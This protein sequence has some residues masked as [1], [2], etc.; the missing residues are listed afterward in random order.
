MKSLSCLRLCL[1]EYYKSQV[2]T[3]LSCLKRQCTSGN[4]P[5]P[6]MTDLY[7]GSYQAQQHQHL[8]QRSNLPLHSL[9]YYVL[10]CTHRLKTSSLIWLTF[11]KYICFRPFGPQFYLEWFYTAFPPPPPSSG[12]QRNKA[13]TVPSSQYLSNT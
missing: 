11:M 7:S 6:Q 5:T 10:T 12:I 13:Y 2:Q 8:L 1:L 3:V 4:T 9:L